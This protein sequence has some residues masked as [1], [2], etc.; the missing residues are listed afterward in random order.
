M[1]TLTLLFLFVYSLGMA[2]WVIVL[3][4]TI[5]AKESWE[6][7]LREAYI[8]VRDHIKTVEKDN[9]ALNN[10]ITVAGRTND[11]LRGELMNIYNR[12]NELQAAYS[13]EQANFEACK[14]LA[15]AAQRDLLQA[16]EYAYQN[17]PHCEYI[18]IALSYIRKCNEHINDIQKVLGD[19]VELEKPRSAA[20]PINW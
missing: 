12:I 7:Q 15:R 5:K 18:A 6:Y 11:E 13:T 3:K 1:L 20:F 2:R 16:S 19:V 4:S 14:S 8:R 10:M 9:V 17:H